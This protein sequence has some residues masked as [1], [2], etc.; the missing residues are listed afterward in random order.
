MQRALLCRRLHTHGLGLRLGLR[1]EAGFVGSCAAADQQDG[2]CSV[3][4]KAQDMSL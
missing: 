2:K 3:K 4:L 1:V